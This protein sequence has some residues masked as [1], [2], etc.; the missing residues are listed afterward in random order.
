MV[1]VTCYVVAR[2]PKPIATNAKCRLHRAMSE[3]GGKAE[4]ICS[5]EFFSV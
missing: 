5:H 3:F 2:P 1:T 4:D